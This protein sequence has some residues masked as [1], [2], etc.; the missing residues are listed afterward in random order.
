LRLPCHGAD[1]DKTKPSP[2]RASSVGMLF[3]GAL[4]AFELDFEG[5]QFA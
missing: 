2:A 3:S 4:A 5:E 1:F